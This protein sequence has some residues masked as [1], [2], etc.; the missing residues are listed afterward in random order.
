MKT[1]KGCKYLKYSRKCLL[2]YVLIK[3]IGYTTHLRWLP[4]LPWLHPSGMFRIY[5][6]FKYFPMFFV[7]SW[8]NYA[9]CFSLLDL[10]SWHADGPLVVEAL[11]S[12]GPQAGGLLCGRKYEKTPAGGGVPR[13]RAAATLLPGWEPWHGAVRHRLSSHKKCPSGGKFIRT[14]ARLSQLERRPVSL[15]PSSLGE[16][17]IVGKSWLHRYCQKLEGSLKKVDLANIH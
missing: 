9:A 15:Q 4:N 17:S 5:L 13:K 8:S 3:F 16:M 1:F 10:Q 14:H 12:V 11:G 2:Y 7:R 6:H